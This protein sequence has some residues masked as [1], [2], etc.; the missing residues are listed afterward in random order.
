MSLKAETDSD[1]NGMGPGTDK[2]PAWIGVLVGEMGQGSPPPKS[3]GEVSPDFD[4]RIGVQRWGQ[5]TVCKAWL[6]VL[7]GTW[8]EVAEVDA[9]EC[10]T[11][12]GCNMDWHSL[13]ISALFC[14]CLMGYHAHAISHICH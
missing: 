8:A 10:R 14:G 7:N 2:M 12:C 1:G 11:F 5:K 4:R 9:Q 6:W 3:M 13:C